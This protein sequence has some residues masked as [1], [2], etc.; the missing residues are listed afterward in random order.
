MSLVQF[1]I[2]ARNATSE[3]TL[4]TVIEQALSHPSTFTFGELLALPNIAGLEKSSDQ[5]AVKCFKTIQLLA[6]GT[7]SDFKA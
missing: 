5:N 2:L 1:V 3:K 7:M 4:P 6:Y